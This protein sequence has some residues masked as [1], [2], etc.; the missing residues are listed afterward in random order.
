MSDG[1]EIGEFEEDGASDEL[2]ALIR[3][4]V[5]RLDDAAMAKGFCGVDVSGARANMALLAT[6]ISNHKGSAGVP[7]WKV[8]EWAQRIDETFIAVQS[9]ILRRPDQMLPVGASIVVPTHHPRIPWLIVAP[10]MEMPE[11]VPAQ[12]SGRALRAALR[13][14][15]RHQE[16]NSDIFCPGLGTLTGRVAPELAAQEMASAYAAWLLRTK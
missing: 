15:D 9:A 10:T 8:K 16:L 12:H 14:V 11:A 7:R 13:L 6:I 3:W 2:S 5:Q 1:Y 4:L